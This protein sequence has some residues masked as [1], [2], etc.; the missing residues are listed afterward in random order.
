MKIRWVGVALVWAGVCSA[1]GQVAA[2]RPITFADLMAMKR[3]SDPQISPSGKWVMFSVMDVSLEK[4]TKTTHLWVVALDP[5]HDDKTVTNGAPGAERQM[6]SNSGETFGRFSPD[7]KFVSYTGSPT[8]DDPVSRITIATWDEKTGT[9]GM[10]RTLKAVSGDA[11]GAIWSP[12]S[13]HFLFTTDVYPECSDKS[14][15]TEEDACDAAKDAAADKSPV[16]AQVW[17][18][19]LYRHWDHY[20]G[21][22][23]SHI[24]EADFSLDG[25]NPRDLTPASAVGNAET[26]T[27]FVGGVQN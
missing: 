13:K 15:W 23:R 16:K 22:K 26:P 19:L 9:I 12:D 25:A 21:K 27:F 8:K 10:G 1:W 17:D 14:T 5:T 4:N 24:I 7:G 20:T 6:T 18:A 2:K 11:D 3:V